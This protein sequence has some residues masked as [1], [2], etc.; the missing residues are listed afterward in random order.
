MINEVRDETPEAKT[1]R[2]L[3]RY[4]RRAIEKVVSEFNSKNQALLFSTKQDE[5]AQSE[6]RVSALNGDFKSKE[7]RTA[8]EEVF[9]KEWHYR[10]QIRNNQ[11]KP[12]AYED[13]VEKR[14]WK[15]GWTYEEFKHGSK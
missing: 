15:Y 7:E 1:F 4:D 3:K 12:V 10:S 11:I 13:A 14:I 5:L 9:A 8:Y 2:L 6:K